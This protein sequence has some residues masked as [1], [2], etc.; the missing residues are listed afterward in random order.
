MM[1]YDLTKNNR[2]Y[3]KGKTKTEINDFLFEL[4]MDRLIK[5]RG[6]NHD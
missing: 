3:F 1:I 4:Y 2:D 6:K 5:L